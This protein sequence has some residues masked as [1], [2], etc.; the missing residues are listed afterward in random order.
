MYTIHLVNTCFFKDPFKDVSDD[1]KDELTLS[2][3]LENK[4]YAS[5]KKFHT[6]QLLGSLYQFIVI[7]IRTCPVKYKGWL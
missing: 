6:D 3:E 5:L 7:Y 1:F 2:T 4:F